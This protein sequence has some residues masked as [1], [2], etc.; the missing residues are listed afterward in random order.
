[1]PGHT[2]PFLRDELV[3]FIESVKLGENRQAGRP[4]PRHPHGQSHFCFCTTSPRPLRLRTPTSSDL[5]CTLDVRTER[6][7]SIT[8]GPVHVHLI[9]LLATTCSAGISVLDRGQVKVIV[10]CSL[11]QGWQAGVCQNCREI[12]ASMWVEGFGSRFGVD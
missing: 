6:K 5:R 4:S 9:P 8:T 3:K 10:E 11:L 1:M 12:L 2:G 7:C